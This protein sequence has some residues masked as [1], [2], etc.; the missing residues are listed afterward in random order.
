MI[1]RYSASENFTSSLPV[2]SI[3][4][5]TQAPKYIKDLC[6]HLTDITAPAAVAYAYRTIS[7]G[8]T[9]HLSQWGV[10]VW[11]GDRHHSLTNEC[12]GEE[13]GQGNGETRVARMHVM[14]GQAGTLSH[15]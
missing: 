13:A 1:W 7:T 14:L 11:V 15:T 10:C 2:A 4:R 9:N 8:S 5:R 12:R 6:T 3:W